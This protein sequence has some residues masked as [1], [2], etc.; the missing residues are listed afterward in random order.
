M[1][2]K[3]ARVVRYALGHWPSLLA[4]LSLSLALSALAALQPWPLKILVDYG[5]GAAGPAQP[6]YV[7]LAALAGLALFAATAALDAAVTRAWSALG[8][9][10]VYDLA[11]DL[12]LRLQRLSL[13]F[14]ARR[15]V[16]DS[17]TRITSDAW[18][19]H[20]VTDSILISPARHLFA[21]ASVGALAWQLDP[22]LTWLTITVAP[23][24]AVSAWY[25][26][27]HLKGFERRKIEA[28]ARLASFLQQ[29]LGA[30]PLVQAFAA[31]PRN[32]KLFGALA[33]DVVKANRAAAAVGSAYSGVNAVS[34]TLGMA[35]VLYVGGQRVLAHELSLG[36]LLVFV[37]YLRTLDAASRGLLATY[38]K[39]RASEVSIERVLEIM[40]AT[41]AVV[42]APGARTLSEPRPA[43][44]GHLVF[45][46]V[47]FAYEPGRPVIKEVSLEL[48]PGETVA[49]VGHTGAGKSTLASLVPRFFDPLGGRVLLDGV[50][51]RGIQLASLRAQVA[52]VLQEP[53]LLPLTVAENIGYGSP[54]ASRD[55]II[56]A[57]V[58]ANAHEFIR[59]LP[60]GYDTVLGEQGAT[61]S[62]GERQRLAIA[63]AFLKRAR[64]LV[65]DEP[66]SALD[67]H[68]EKLVVEALQRLVA[69]STTLIIAH[70]L[71]T[72]RHASRV[73]VLEEGR[74][75]ETG[76]HADLLTAGGRYAQFHR[77]QSL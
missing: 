42:D 53:F 28:Q 55:E 7:V 68:T 67:S 60:H 30:M 39:L 18:C 45:E 47:S 51:L 1:G 31:A 66:T 46:R 12:F 52:V 29:L 38:G 15:H 24:L 5:L 4:I 33:A 26:G 74:L 70:R 69:G 40:D 44:G 9:R 50:D 21:L 76:T 27:A 57:A 20:A 59:E 77:L 34:V 35:L 71:S 22:G 10:M 13:L 61:L 36:S 75:I 14:H 62:G 32:R 17:I 58:A 63:R 37:A 64:V 73:A 23:L 72:V 65:M 11:G 54:S 48:E 25:F 19:V 2:S 6:R 41:E 56:A 8:Q 16:G 49:L 43:H 3:Y